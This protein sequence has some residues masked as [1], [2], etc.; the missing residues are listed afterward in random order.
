M[1]VA[2]KLL[3]IACG[4]LAR[5]I[6]WLKKTNHWNNLDIQCLDAEL[7]NRPERIPEQLEKV[8]QQRQGQYQRLYVAYGDCGTGGGIDRVIARWGVERL[9]GAHCYE[10][11]ATPTQFQALADEE[12]GTFYLTDFLVRHFE[13][14][15]MEGLKINTYPQLRD[16]YFG[17]YTRVVY[18]AQTKDDALLDAA[19]AAARALG[20]AFDVRYTGLGDLAHQLEEQIIRIPSDNGVAHAAH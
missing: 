13:R 5:E 15:V 17:H 6:Q 9:P 19:G 16:D 12:P 1:A 8:I 7:H 18:L 11:F 14:L 20:L 4:A 3:V 2:G 10:V